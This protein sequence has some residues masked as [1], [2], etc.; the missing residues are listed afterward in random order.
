MKY[1]VYDAET[2]T[3]T[4]KDTHAIEKKTGVAKFPQ[5]Q[6]K[7]P[8]IQYVYNWSHFDNRDLCSNGTSSSSW[9]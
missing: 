7:N 9:V 4:K 2:Y 5:R 6:N 8:P 1:G 3:A